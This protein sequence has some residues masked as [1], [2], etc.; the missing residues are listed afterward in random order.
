[1]TS[2]IESET[3]MSNQQTNYRAFIGTFFEIIDILEY[4]IEKV[5]GTQLFYTHN[6]YK[7]RDRF[8]QKL[9]STLRFT[10]LSYAIF[11]IS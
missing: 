10:L 11:S 6:L 8:G 1:M 4:R 5:I 3:V 7:H 9:S 2:K